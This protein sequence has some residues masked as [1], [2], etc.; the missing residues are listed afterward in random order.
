MTR[1]KITCN[2]ESHWHAGMSAYVR[3]DSVDPKKVC[4]NIDLA[5]HPVFS[6]AASVKKNGPWAC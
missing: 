6:R 5:H 4:G 3:G 2:D 1:I